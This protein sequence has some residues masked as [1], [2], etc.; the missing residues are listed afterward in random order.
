MEK[1]KKFLIGTALVIGAISWLGSI[2]NKDGSAIAHNAGPQ[3]GIAEIRVG[4][5]RWSK[6]GFGNVMEASF[7]ITNQNRYPVK[8][9]VVKCIHFAPSGSAID[10]NTRTVY[11]RIPVGQTILVHELNMGFIHTQATRSYCSVTDFEPA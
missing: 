6:E 9:L 7:S 8:D 10:S 4:N 5:L 1:L 2:P 11:Q 3:G